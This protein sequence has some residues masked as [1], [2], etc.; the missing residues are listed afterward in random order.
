MKT[1]ISFISLLSIFYN[2]FIIYLDGFIIFLYIYKKLIK[3]DQ[4]FNF[5]CFFTYYKKKKYIRL[6]SGK[7]L[8]E[9][10][11]ENVLLNED[12]ITYVIK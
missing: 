8:Q 11:N 3:S 9:K 2:L 10:I 4:F 12:D 6:Y 1:L 7:T 5:I